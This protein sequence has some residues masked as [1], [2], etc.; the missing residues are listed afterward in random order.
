MKI[1][2]LRNIFMLAENFCHALSYERILSK[3]E[4]VRI[5]VFYDGDSERAKKSIESALNQT[6]PHKKI[7]LTLL[8]TENSSELLKVIGDQI[9]EIEFVSKSKLP[10]KICSDEGSY[11]QFILP[12]DILLPDKIKNS[13]ELMHSTTHKG[14]VVISN[15][16]S[17]LEE[18]LPKETKLNYSLGIDSCRFNMIWVKQLLS[19]SE[20]FKSCLSRA[21]F[22]QKVF[23]KSEW[24]HSWL[25]DRSS[26]LEIDSISFFI[27]AAV[28]FYVD[29][30]NEK[31]VE[32]GCK[33]WNETD[34]DRFNNIFESISEQMSKFK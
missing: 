31:L 27:S 21:F 26:N 22:K 14:D 28:G 8:T 17:P 24:I 30:F 4:I 7:Y 16:N 20:F 12:G 6:Y 3:H 1:D 32:R 25:D 34:I 13:I 15:I 19:R 23:S 2:P 18:S 9:S 29:F 10:E 11:I 5:F 33:T